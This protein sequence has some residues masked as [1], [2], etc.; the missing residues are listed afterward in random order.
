ME[1]PVKFL[2]FASAYVDTGRSLAPT[3]SGLGGIEGQKKHLPY[4]WAPGATNEQQEPKVLPIPSL[5]GP[6]KGAAPGP[7]PVPSGV[8]TLGHKRIPD[9]Q[10]EAGILPLLL[11][12]TTPFLIW[13][14]KIDKPTGGPLPPSL[15]ASLWPSREATKHQTQNTAQSRH[16][17]VN[18]G[19]QRQH[20]KRKEKPRDGAHL[21]FWLVVV[22]NVDST[23]GRQG[24]GQSH[25]NTIAPFIRLFQFIKML[26]SP[27][28]T[29]Q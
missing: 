17:A 18:R 29:L 10:E 19:L 5:P 20:Q 21:T 7:Q 22:S 4:V 16:S 8:S 28:N 25:W 2:N 23:S 6:G 13:P 11:K 27:E 24:Q 1:L 15:W 12:A 14:K 26:P 9:I 3:K